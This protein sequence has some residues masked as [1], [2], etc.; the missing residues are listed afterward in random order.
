[1]GLLNEWV[2]ALLRVA[3]G[4]LVAALGRSILHDKGGRRVQ[5]HRV[6]L[7]AGGGDGFPAHR[8]VSA[9]W[10]YPAG[11]QLHPLLRPRKPSRTAQ[12]R[13]A[14]SAWPV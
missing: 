5:R 2:R 7:F 13:D 14:G 11:A 6:D 12:R 9:A 8:R 10:T 3:G 1:M 4:V